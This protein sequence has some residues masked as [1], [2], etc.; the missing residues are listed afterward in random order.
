MN[1]ADDRGA[2]GRRED[3][4][5]VAGTGPAT[6]SA[7]PANRADSAI[8]GR[9][10]GGDLPCVMCGYNLRGLSIRSVCPECGAGVRATILSVVDPQAAVLQPIARPHL[11]AASLLA[12]T[13]GGAAAVLLHWVPQ[14]TDL[15]RHLG[16]RAGWAP[17]LGIA[18]AASIAISGLGALGI[19]RPHVGIPRTQTLAAIIAAALYV[20]LGLLVV[21][22]WSLRA[23][24]GGPDYLRGWA[25]DAATTQAAVLTCAVLIA[26]LVLLR[27]IARLL[28][29]RSLLLRSGRVDR[30]TLLAMA[31][32]A[33]VLGAGHMVGRLSVVAPGEMGEITRVLGLA[34]VVIGSVLLSL[35]S[36]GAVVDGFRITRA[37][38]RPRRTLRQV[39]RSGIGPPV[40]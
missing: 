8:L 24:F 10:L 20:P 18:I 39:V 3:R 27:P 36:L 15:T 12:W 28:V 23:R 37:I 25:P 40:G 29:A 34:M 21:E 7:A 5:D 30:Q 9:Q 32:A 14:A 19:S 1:P 22:T 31:M 2:P 4:T 11:V 6:S 16:L 17:D 13:I 38:L 35:G 26:I 33:A